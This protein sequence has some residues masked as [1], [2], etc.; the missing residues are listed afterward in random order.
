MI[1]KTQLPS[2][3]EEL[4]K[5]LMGVTDFKI[6]LENDLSSNSMDVYLEDMHSRRVIEL[7]SGMEKTIASLAIRV[8]LINISSIPRSDI[9]IVDEG[10][11]ALD[12]ENMQS[13]LE[14][15]NM[16]RT[17]FKSVLIISHEPAIK[18]VADRILEVKNDGIESKIEA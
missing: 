7:G 14:M 17:Y 5:I 9:F 16:L 12:E 18:E 10:F 11:T 15:L 4:D 13:C 2:I 1:L 8:A 3:N 6:V